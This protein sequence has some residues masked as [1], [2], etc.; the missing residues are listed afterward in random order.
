LELGTI[1]TKLHPAQ[2]PKHT[3]MTWRSLHGKLTVRC[4]PS[5]QVKLICSKD[6]THPTLV[7]TNNSWNRKMFHKVPQKRQTTSP[8]HIVS[9]MWWTFLKM[10][11][12]NENL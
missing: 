6:S 10:W 9:N 2:T 12:P 3:D 11:R 8:F 5:V 1:D 7:Q 4:P